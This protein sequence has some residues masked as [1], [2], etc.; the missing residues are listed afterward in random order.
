M[1]LE[2]GA[3]VCL[4]MLAIGAS[5][6]D[7]AMTQRWR[8]LGPSGGSVSTLVID[9][10]DT[11]TIYSATQNNGVFKT[12]DGGATWSAANAGLPSGSAVITLAMDPLDPN[13]LYAAID[14][15]G[16]FKTSDG[17]MTWKPARAGLPQYY[18]PSYDDA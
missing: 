1:R 10:Q 17:G 6:A 9:P 2:A 16:I 13:T 4:V 12:K 7:S 3:A 11:G 15:Q 18:P 8:S 5:G 14:S